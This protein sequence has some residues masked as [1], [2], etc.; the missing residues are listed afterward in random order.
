MT[1]LDN[2]FRFLAGDAARAGR[3]TPLPE[4]RRVEAETN[5][6]RRIRGI[7]F[8]PEQAPRFV[9]LHGM[10]LNAH[11]YDPIALALDTPSL[12]LDLPGH[13][14]SDWRDDANYRPDL[15]ALDVVV[16]LDKLAPEPFTLVGH[17]L[18]GLTAIVVAALRPQLV[19]RLVMIDITPGIVPQQA[20]GSVTEFI[21]GQRAFDTHEEIVDRAVAFGIGTDRDALARGVA[22]NT[23][24]RDDGRWE[25][26]HHFAH[27]DAA[28]VQDASNPKPLSP[29]WAPLEQMH[30]AGLPIMQ[31]AA[32]QGMVDRALQEEWSERLPGSRITTVP[33]PHN[34]H[35]AAP[36]AL[37]ELVRTFAL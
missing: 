10:G 22:L 33:G 13:G 8:D 34:L 17:S 11:G 18:G 4:V 29:L 32:E 2:E 19:Q 28:P 20:S 7:S 23:R 16:A 36:L 27:L 35:E 15:I 31:V 21:T 37:A 25:W 12:A 14:R 24:R 3:T 1:D 30:E 26:T 9:F 5:E 6:G